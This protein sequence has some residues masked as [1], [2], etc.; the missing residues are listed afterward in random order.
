MDTRLAIDAAVKGHHQQHS[1]ALLIL[2]SSSPCSIANSSTDDALSSAVACIEQQRG[3]LDGSTRFDCY[4][5][6]STCTHTHT[7]VSSLSFVRS[8][9]QLLLLLLLLLG[10]S[11][12]SRVLL[13]ISSSFYGNNNNCD[14]F[15]FFVFLFM[16][17]LCSVPLTSYSLVAIRCFAFERCK[18]MTRA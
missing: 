14:I 11:S 13:F 4:W 3:C 5:P 1:N 18:W 8:R 6:K 16:D 10:V 7:N 12:I 2:P 15:F 9:H 17:S